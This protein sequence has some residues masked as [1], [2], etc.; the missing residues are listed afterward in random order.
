MRSPTLAAPAVLLRTAPGHP[1]NL[2]GDFAKDCGP[3]T[4]HLESV[5]RI[6]EAMPPRT[7]RTAAEQR[8]AA[9][10]HDEASSLRRRFLAAYAERIYAELTDGLTRSPRLEELTGLAAAHFPGLVP[11]RAQLAAESRHTQRNKEG[12]E[13]AVGIFLQAV[14]N[15]P[16]AGNHLLRSMLRPTARARAALLDYQLTGHADL[17]IATVT[18]EDGIAQLELCNAEFLN[19]EDDAAVEALETGTDLVLLDPASH[20]GV[21]RGAPQSHPAYAGRRVFSAG[22]NLTHLYHGDISLLGFLLRREAGYIAKFVRGLCL[23]DT[24]GDG[25]WPDADKPWV[26]AVDAFA[27]GGGMQILPTMDRVVAA[28]DSWFSLPAMEEGLVPGVANMRLLHLTGSRLTRRLIFWGRKLRATDPEASLFVDETVPAD[29][30]DGAVRAAAGHLDHPAVGAN[31]RMLN[32]V[33]EP[34]ELFRRYLAQYAY[35]QARQ[36][37]S[38]GLITTLENTWINRNRGGADAGASG[39]E[40]R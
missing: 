29:A 22:I 23:D 31:R 17:G 5:V 6:V 12:W 40:K 20:V 35:E 39:G 16:I 26:A 36:L 14:L 34:L 4:A 7:E 11:T 1:P 8:D 18:R 30:M 15:A 33:E 2:S 37:H 28:D 9:A 13:I 21:L 25:W 19:A 38:P 24:A 32:L 27:I 3:V 10:L